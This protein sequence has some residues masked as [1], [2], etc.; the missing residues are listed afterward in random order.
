MFVKA[1]DV[2]LT[3]LRVALDAGLFDGGEPGGFEEAVDGALRGADARALALLMRVGLL[4]GQAVHGQRQAARGDERLG[5]L[6]DETS[7]D[8]RIGNELAQVLRRAGLHAGGDFFAE[9]FEQEIGHGAASRR[10]AGGAVR[11]APLREGR[12]T[13]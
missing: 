5:A 7:L 4:R 1:G 11:R 12:P 6:I 9:Q 13:P 10:L 2:E 3:L 8:Q